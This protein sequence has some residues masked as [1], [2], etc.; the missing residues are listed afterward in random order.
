M[1]WAHRK[2]TRDIEVTKR[3]HISVIDAVDVR[4]RPP[5]K[6]DDGVGER[7]CR[8]ENERIRASTGQE[9]LKTCVVAIP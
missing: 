1:V 5:V 9:W 4:G 2:N 6:L 3:V 8:K 7:K